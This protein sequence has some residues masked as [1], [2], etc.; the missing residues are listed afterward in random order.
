MNVLHPVVENMIQEKSFELMS[1]S[2]IIS[3]LDSDGCI[4]FANENF[5]KI[6]GFANHEFLHRPHPMIDGSNHA[7]F[8]WHDIRIKTSAGAAWRSKVKNKN[9]AG[10][11]YW[12]DI[13]LM[14]VFDE[15]K[16]VIA[17]LD[18]SHDVTHEL[19]TEERLQ[20]SKEAL[21]ASE[22]HY[23]FLYDNTPVMYFVLSAQAIVKTV[24]KYGA[25]HLGYSIHELEGQPINKLVVSSHQKEATEQINKCFE[26]FHEVHSWQIQKCKKDGSTIWVEETAWTEHSPEGELLIILVSQDITEKKTIND[27]IHTENRLFRN[28]PMVAFKWRN[29][30]GWPIKFVS[31]NVR[32]ILGIEARELIQATKKY[33][34]YIH[35]NDLAIVIE[36]K[37]T[38]ALQKLRYEIDLEYRLL[39]TNG[40]WTWVRDHTIITRNQDGAVQS[41]QGYIY[42][43]TDRKQAQE[44]TQ[45]L[46]TRLVSLIEAMPEA[47]FFKDG[48]GRWLITNE[49][50]KRLFKLHTIDW[51]NK[52]D[53][54][55]AIL[56]PELADAHQ[57][58]EV[59]DERAWV[60]KKLSVLEERIMDEE[61]VLQEFEVRKMPIFNS[62]GSRKAMVIIG[63]N[64]TVRNQHEAELKR[65]KRMLERSMKLAKIGAWE[66]DFE[67]GLIFWSSLV[68]ELAD[69][70]ESYKPEL[71]KILNFY[72]EGES[73]DAVQKAVSDCQLTGVGFELEAETIS[74]K[75]KK[76]WVRLMVE[77]EIVNGKC[78][79]LY[80]YIQ[81]LTEHIELNK[82]NQ[83]LEV[84]FSR[85]VQKS[86]DAIILQNAD[87]EILYSTPAVEKILGYKPEEIFGKR[88]YSFYHPDDIESIAPKLEKILAN[89]GEAFPIVTDRLRHKNGHYVHV[90]GTVTN[91]LEDENV[92][93]AVANIRDV[94][95]RVELHKKNQQ[96]EIKF[97]HL[98]E[99]ISDAIIL[100]AAD[101]TILYSSSAI[102]SILGYQPH[103]LVGKNSQFLF[104][105]EDLMQA[106]VRREQIFH[107]SGGTFPIVV[108]RMRHKEG[109][110]VFVEGTATNLLHNENVRA[111][112]SN[113]RNITERKLLDEQILMKNQ[114]LEKIAWIFSHQVRGP[115][116][117]ILGLAEIFNQADRTDP[118]NNEIL[119][120]ILIPIHHLDEIIS[121]VVGL[122]NEFDLKPWNPPPD[123]YYK[124][125]IN[126]HTTTE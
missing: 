62:N 122:T 96:L 76:H 111:I 118:I 32:T 84:K 7:S 72:Q 125:K 65:T 88:S 100:Q 51:Y 57:L 66:V 97:Q 105:P 13:S 2:S 126:K 114:K 103:E 112:I 14:P 16:N 59:N 110:Y 95:E 119:A 54:E 3:I 101:G 70:S 46:T 99:K 17:Y 120:K 63:A 41:M 34:E 108:E 15:E 109:H 18:I 6:S 117:T 92:R 10:A 115:V 36:A 87:A 98:I 48:Q 8:I 49:V 67:K 104:H 64:V 39:T 50:A 68:R 121:N 47:I 24:N 71:E 102:F 69:V 90:E 53:R 58:C 35:P 29:E 22:L 25:F 113:F 91:L 73:R 124:S 27:A 55:L 79:K 20:E 40:E 77:P 93:A 38:S 86:A 80:G 74:A 21:R 1:N 33:S 116:A 123:F 107:V 26:N 60:D 30:E 106:I 31:P 83:Q 42:D 78:V 81:D 9:I 12:V 5:Q 89:P 75:G 85:L 82:K 94:S 45:L 4:Q 43:C 44:E 56:H 52:T 61:G 37:N 11:H 19:E 28:G 23:Q